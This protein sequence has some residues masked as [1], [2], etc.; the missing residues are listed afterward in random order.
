MA[1]PQYS[2]DEKAAAKVAGAVLFSYH[3]NGTGCPG[4]P[5]KDFGQT[6]TLNAHQAEDIYDAIGDTLKKFKAA[7]ANAGA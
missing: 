1:K 4:F 2:V 3:F 6:M 5:A 7:A